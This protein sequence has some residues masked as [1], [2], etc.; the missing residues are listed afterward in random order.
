MY[1]CDKHRYMFYRGNKIDKCY[2]SVRKV[3]KWLQFVNKQCIVDTE[4]VY[5]PRDG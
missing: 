4:R 5:H 3:K 2:D 1:R